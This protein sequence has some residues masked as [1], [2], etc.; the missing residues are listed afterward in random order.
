MKHGFLIRAAAVCLSLCTALPA[1]ASCN[2]FSD[3]EYAIVS[4][5]NVSSDGFIYD[6][7]ENSTVKITGI[8]NMPALLTIPSEIDGMPVVEIG[9]SAFEN[10][11]ML[12]YLKLP[13]SP[14]KLGKRF[15]S[16]CISLVSVDLAGSVSSLPLG[17]FEECRNLA[18]IEGMSAVTEIGD[19]AFAGCSA[20][21]HIKISDSLT[22]LGNEAFRG[23]T[24]LSS[25]TL[26]ETLTFLGESIFWGCENLVRAEV[27]GSAEIPKYAF[28]NCTAL[29]EVIIGD[30]VESIDEEAFRSCR[31]LYTVRFGKKVN[32]IADYAFHACDSLTEITFS[33]SKDEITVGDGNE[34]LGLGN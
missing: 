31:A 11:D 6:K 28:L 10:N 34:S 8:E 29:T 23:C 12:L 17:A 3:T 21:A 32:N 20:L 9:D 25:V 15:C 7:Y 27:N 18:M 2:S 13:S 14:I 26:P 33:G 4:E 19:Q 24:S 30:S 5:S 22:S 1:L 16:G